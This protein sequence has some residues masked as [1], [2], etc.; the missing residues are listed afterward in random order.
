MRRKYSSQNAGSNRPG[1]FS[2][3]VNCAQR[4]GRSNHSGSGPAASTPAAAVA[5]A[6]PAS[7]ERTMKSRREIDVTSEAVFHRELDDALAALARDLA[8]RSAVRVAVRARPV[9]MIQRVERLRAELQLLP[10]DERH[11]LPHAE[12][13]VPRAWIAQPVPRLHAERSGRRPR[14]RGRIEPRRRRRK[15]SVVDVRIADEIP[16]LVAA[17]G[18]DAGEVVVAAY[19]ERGA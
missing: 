8:E 9:R 1:S 15:R 11:C 10:A 7:V 14:E 13:E 3:S 5:I 4:I 18:T 2:T 17:A 16:E 19:G 6:A 12:I